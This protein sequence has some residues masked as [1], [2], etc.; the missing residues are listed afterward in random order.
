MRTEILLRASVASSSLHVDE[1]REWSQAVFDDETTRRMADVAWNVGIRAPLFDHRVLQLGEEMHVFDRPLKPKMKASDQ[2]A[3]GRCWGFAGLSFLRRLLVAKLHLPETFELSQTHLLFYDKL[4]KSHAFLRH[5]IA[6]RARPA[7]DRCVMHLLRSPVE[8]GGDF[9]MFAALVHKYGVVPA[10]V[11]PGN[12]PSSNTS[13]LNRLLRLLLRQS[14][15][16]LRC[17]D[18]DLAAR[19]AEVASTLRRVHRLLCVCFGAPP[20]R[21]T[22]TYAA[23]D[24]ESD[25][26]VVRSVEHTPRELFDACGE[27]LLDF[28]VLVNVPSSEKAFGESY[29]VDFLQTVLGDAPP[30]YRNVSAETLAEASKRTLDA[31]KAVWFACEFDVLRLRDDGL[32]HHGLLQ[33]DRAIGEPMERDK[34]QRIDSQATEVDHAMLLTGYHQGPRGEGVERWQVENSHG[35]LNADGYL[36]MTDTWFRDH[37]FSVAVPRSSVPAGAVRRDRPPIRLPPWDVLGMVARVT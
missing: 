3:T 4:E 21:F 36:A 13:L 37:V 14:A 35:T 16:R 31:G 18:V 11:M 17:P 1:V 2:E 34:A 26:D 9:A 33:H 32:L 15:A 12:A 28:D 5:M 20:E 22:W 7:D 10:S 25:D 29:T 30:V 19:E 27:D 6:M 24:P 8:D 23:K